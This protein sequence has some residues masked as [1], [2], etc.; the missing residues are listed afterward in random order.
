MV[1]KRKMKVMDNELNVPKRVAK[2]PPD[3]LRDN[4]DKP[5]SLRYVDEGNKDIRALIFNIVTALII[6][7]VISIAVR[8]KTDGTLFTIA[9][10]LVVVWILGIKVR[11]R[12]WTV[13]PSRQAYIYLDSLYSKRIIVYKQGGHFTRW[14]S[15]KQEDKVDFQKHELI[16]AKKS[17]K[18]SIVFPTKD[19]KATISADI[20][21]FFRRR[22]SEEAL[23][24]SLKYQIGELEA[25]IKSTVVEKLSEI[26]GAND[27]KDILRLK[28]QVAEEVANLFAGEGKISKFEDDTGTEIR[29]PILDDLDLTESSKEIFGT[30]AKV[31]V[32]VDG[33]KKLIASGVSPKEAATIAQVAEGAATREIITIE[34]VENAEV[35]AVGGASMA[36][37]ANSRKERK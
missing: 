28:G 24:K 27:Y 36:V 13:V 5:L 21:I 2:T 32:I 37:A 31:D 8:M 23:S 9:L 25:L 6:F 12:L 14:T 17:E 3:G 29:N 15:E 33:V 18:T 20:T 16:S 34:G 1:Q 22:D 30:G 19:G 35:V 10:P 11:D 4:L 26:G 7:L